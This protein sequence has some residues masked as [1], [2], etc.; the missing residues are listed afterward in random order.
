MRTNEEIEQ[1]DHAGSHELMHMAMND[2]NI[3]DYPS[4]VYNSVPNEYFSLFQRQVGLN[5]HAVL[6]ERRVGL[7]LQHGEYDVVC[8]RCFIEVV[9]M[10]VRY[11]ARCI[12]TAENSCRLQWGQDRL[13]QIQWNLLLNECEE[14][15]IRLTMELT[16]VLKH[17]HDVKKQL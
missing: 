7:I 2:V 8:A 10:E 15:T 14:F 4:A 16:A 1:L 6:F 9:E 12:L 11:V 13:N 5:W 17:P 3:Y